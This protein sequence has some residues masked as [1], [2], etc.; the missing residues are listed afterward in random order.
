M[1]DVRFAFLC[2]FPS[3]LLS[4]IARSVK[5]YPTELKRSTKQKFKFPNRWVEYVL[6]ELSEL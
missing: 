3:A 1:A 4:S 6:L 5:M 2:N